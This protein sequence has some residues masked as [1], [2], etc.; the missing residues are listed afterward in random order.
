[1][2][3]LVLGLS[4][5]L[6]FSAF[7]SSENDIF[8]P[9]QNTSFSLGEE[10][11]FKMTYGFFNVGRG[12]AKIHPNYHKINGRDCFKVD[13][14][15]RTVGMVDWVADVNDQWGAYVDTAALVP[16]QFYRKIREG[17][18]KKDEWTDFDHANR[19]IT[20]KSLDKQGK[21]KEPKT[22]DSPALV[23]DMISGFLYLRVMDFSK[24]KVN[25]TVLVTGFFEDE[26]YKLKIV[27]RGKDKVK[28]KVGKVHA[29]KFSPVMPKNKVFEDGSSIT[30]WFSDDKNRIPL[31]IDADMFIGSAGV[32]LV[33]YKNLRNPINFV[34]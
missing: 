21:M 26:F 3:K 1:M 8:T 12:S 32:E 10:I 19:K 23:R 18:Y 25:D 31:K 29:L 34:K 2:K 16:H 30:A 20:V 14:T 15:G 17:K 27:Y 7:I 33:S 22:Y 13:V 11:H 28:L 4:T 6:F 24:L 9:V 5:L